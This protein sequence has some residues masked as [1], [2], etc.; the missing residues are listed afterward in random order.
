MSKTY[1]CTATIRVTVEA[2]DEF[3]A[4]YEAMAQ[5]DVG[6]IEWDVEEGS[7]EETDSS[8]SLTNVTTKA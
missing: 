7:L 4:P 8:Q 1:I 3:D 5:V 2:D 6:D